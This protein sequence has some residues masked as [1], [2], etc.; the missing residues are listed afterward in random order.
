MDAPRDALD[1]H[2]KLRKALPPAL[3]HLLH[4]RCEAAMAWER[5]Q[6]DGILADAERAA[7]ADWTDFRVAQLPAKS[8]RTLA[9]IGLEAQV[10]PWFQT[11]GR[12]ESPP[13]WLA[14]PE[15][16]YFTLGGPIGRDQHPLLLF[17]A[18]PEDGG[19]GW[20]W[21]VGTAESVPAAV[22]GG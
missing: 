9:L 20:G 17:R 12:R 8:Q 14:H 7:G 16:G 10:L 22:P 4:A 11:R 18:R 19:L 13:A 2:R 5:K 3:F 6:L 1:L 15:K 21:S